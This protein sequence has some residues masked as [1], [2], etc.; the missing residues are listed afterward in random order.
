MWKCELWAEHLNAPPL[1]SL[2]AVLWQGLVFGFFNLF[3]LVLFSLGEML[4]TAPRA[5][6]RVDVS[7][8]R[9][10]WYTEGMEHTLVASVVN[11]DFPVLH[12]QGI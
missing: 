6:V 3:V 4:T 5:A 11:Q 10:S 9:R 8:L 12:T 7:V 1:P 2:T